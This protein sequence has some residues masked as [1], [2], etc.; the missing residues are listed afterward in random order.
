MFFLK[1]KNEIT[2]TNILKINAVGFKKIT[3]NPKMVINAIYPLAPPCP[4][5]AYRT[6]TKNRIIKNGTI[7]LMSY[8]ITYKNTMLI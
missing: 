6:A 7:K 2:E 4:T 1:Y 5:E 3:E 8:I